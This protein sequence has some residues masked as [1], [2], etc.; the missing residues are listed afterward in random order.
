MLEV[1]LGRRLQALL[2][3]VPL[4]PTKLTAR[5]RRTVGVHALERGPHCGPRFALEHPRDAHSGNEAFVQVPA[6]S[7]PVDRYDAPCS[8]QGRGQS[9]VGVQRVPAVL[10]FEIT[11]QILSEPRPHR[12]IVDR[13]T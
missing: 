8:E 10:I 11:V 5:C 13:R 6:Y 1:D 9:H 7:Y 12:P 3:A 2:V 4:A